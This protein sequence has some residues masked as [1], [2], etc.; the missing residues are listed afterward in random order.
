MIIPPR[1]YDEYFSFE[2]HCTRVIIYSRVCRG[3][4]ETRME[5]KNKDYKGETIKK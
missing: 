1:F 2:L 4:V 3:F 5:L